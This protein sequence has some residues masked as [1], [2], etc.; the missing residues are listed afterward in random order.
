[1][2][3]KGDCKT[4]LKKMESNSIDLIYLDPPFSPRKSNHKRRETIRKSTLLTIAG[5]VSNI[6]EVI[7][8]KG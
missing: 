2:I 3:K 8:K 6:T 5:R 1:M 7:L 4:E